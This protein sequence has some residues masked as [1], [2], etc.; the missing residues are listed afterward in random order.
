MRDT[1]ELAEI[2]IYAGGIWPAAVDASSFPSLGSG[3]VPELRTPV[4]TQLAFEGHVVVVVQGRAVLHVTS[5]VS[6]ELS[7]AVDAAGVFAKKY[8]GPKA[9]WRLGFIIQLR[10]PVPDG[11]ETGYDA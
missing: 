2:L 3:A 9:S 7:P 1:I 10:C 8:V 4:L 11:R 6:T 5:P